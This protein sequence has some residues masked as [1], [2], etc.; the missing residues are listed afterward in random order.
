MRL[1]TADKMGVTGSTDCKN[2]LTGVMSALEHLL[3]RGWRPTRTIVL[4]FGFDEEIGGPQ[5]AATIF[6]FLLERY[7]KVG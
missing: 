4:A 5:G 6:P 2:S 1:R 3:E 7:G